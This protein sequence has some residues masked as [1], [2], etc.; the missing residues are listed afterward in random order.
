MYIIIFV[1]AP[2]KPQASH[3]AHE[4]IAHKLAACVNM[5]E[6]VE[7]LFWWQGKVDRA[8]EVLLVIKSTNAKLPKIIQ[9]VKAI[10]SYECPEI[11]AL[12]VIGG[13]KP[14][15]KWIDESLR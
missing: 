12:P 13:Y 14:Y 5:L 2:D 9:V 11:I 4:L 1:T 10:H 7:S 3:I 8:E 15:L 6:H